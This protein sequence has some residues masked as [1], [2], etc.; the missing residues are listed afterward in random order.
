M[1]LI[2]TSMVIRRCYA[3]LDFLK[4]SNGVMTGIEFGTL[5]IIESLQRKFPDQEIV[6]CLDSK[7]S[8]RK[9]K[10]PMYKA[11]RSRIPSDTYYGRLNVFIKF[12]KCVYVTVEA[13]GFEADDVIYKMSLQPG[14]HYI[15][16][17]DHDL[18]QAVGVNV[19]MLKSFQS[20]LYHWDAA[21]V[22]EEYGVPP[23][24]LAEY[25]AF[26]GD[27][28][29]NVIGVSRIKKK[30]LASLIIW[31][32]EKNKTISEILEEIK[33]AEWGALLK[34]NIVAFIDAGE[35]HKNYELV[36][37]GGDVEAMVVNQPTND[38]TFIV[39]RLKHWEIYS[40][41]LSSKYGVLGSEDF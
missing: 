33:T 11:N 2:D 26:V 8:W 39:E 38:E 25:M 19:T 20:K 7:K 5:R 23:K 40:L 16:S 32:H 1:I 24:Y 12:L 27:K 22:L 34:A 17:N 30:F 29:D 21:K 10:Y 31:A 41:K 37:L 15:Y 13:E 35:F 9:D 3:K 14:K 6:L 28:G 18:L 4:T 36:K